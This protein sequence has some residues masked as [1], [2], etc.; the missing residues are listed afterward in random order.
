M[1]QAFRRAR[2]EAKLPPQPVPPETWTVHNRLRY[3]NDGTFGWVLQQMWRSSSGRE[4]WRTIQNLPASPLELM[5]D[6]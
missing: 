6:E 4:E 2:R 3:H 5:L 1:S